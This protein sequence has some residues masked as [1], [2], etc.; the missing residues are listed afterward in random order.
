M[1][2]TLILDIFGIS[3]I[4]NVLDIHFNIFNSYK[5]HLKTNFESNTCVVP[6][7]PVED[8]LG[9]SLTSLELQL[10]FKQHGFEL[11]V[12]HLIHRL[13]SVVNTAVLFDLQLLD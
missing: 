12:V 7:T 10:T 8:S 9:H 3:D 6:E 1:L 5:I 4:F 13:F 2:I 11:W